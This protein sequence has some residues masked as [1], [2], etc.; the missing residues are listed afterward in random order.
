MLNRFFEYFLINILNGAK[1]KRKGRLGSKPT[2]GVTPP[3]DYTILGHL[4]PEAIMPA[5]DPIARQLND[6]GVVAL[7]PEARMR[8]LYLLGATGTGKTNLLLRLIES[9]IQ[10]QR[11]F[12]V[13]DLRGDLVDRILLRLASAAPSETWQKRLLLIDLRNSESS[14]GFNPLSGEGDAYTRALLMLS[15]LKKQSDS[16]GVQLEET[17]RNSLLALSVTGWTLLEIGPLLTNSA[18]RAQVLDGVNDSQVKAFF[19]RFAQL[20][21]AEQNKWTG[22]VLNKIT[23]LISIPTLRFLFGQRQG[24]SFRELLDKQP[25]MIILI[26]LAVDRLHDAARLTGGLLISNFQAA[27][28]A[29]VEQPED[30]RVPAHLYVDEFECMASDKFE[31]IVAEGRRFRVG[32]TLSHQN[33]SQ[34]PT[35][36]RQVIRNNVHTQVYFQ[37]G[38]LDAGELAKEI[39]A[40]KGSDEVRAALM[41]Q[42]TGEAYLVR[43][44]QPSAKMRTLR[45]TD[46]KITASQI[47]KLRA[48]SYATYGLPRAQ[49]DRE[50]RER[51]GEFGNM[52]ASQ[53]VRGSNAKAPR[54]GATY[55][56]RHDK[57]SRFGPG[58]PQ[59]DDAQG[60]TGQPNDDDTSAPSLETPEASSPPATPGKP[61]RRTLK[62]KDAPA[63]DKRRP[64]EPAKDKKTKGGDTADGQ[65]TE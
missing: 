31:E 1:R 48:V 50:L 5:A 18:F 65:S 42:A 49:I 28:M 17:L 33:L 14:V 43:R 22:A 21:A 2:P 61:A 10:N 38:A 41:S 40:G 39:G 64:K 37:T 35:N 27:I 44:G 46:P 29:R 51:E 55:E 32:L 34:L 54:G 36:L 4:I 47:E 60:D 25:G 11:A 19:E 7:S 3:P 20:S 26:S 24:F 62:P 59:P 23:P 6:A 52:G 45:S 16:W 30:Q 53:P 12:C 58:T 9:D 63:K 8:H 15:V 57:L 56:I 13:I